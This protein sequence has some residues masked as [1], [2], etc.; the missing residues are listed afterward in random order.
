[1]YFSLQ[2]LAQLFQSAEGTSWRDLG[3]ISNNTDK[4]VKD[5]QGSRGLE[6]G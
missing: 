2:V 3:A 6:K 4:I 1:M 5:R